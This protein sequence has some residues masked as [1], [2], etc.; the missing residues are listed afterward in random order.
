MIEHCWKYHKE[1]P[2]VECEICKKIV[3]SA[4]YED[5][6]KSHDEPKK[7]VDKRRNF[8]KVFV[9]VKSDNKYYFDVKYQCNLC[10]QKLDYSELDKHRELH[11]KNQ[12]GLKI[13]SLVKKIQMGKKRN[14]EDEN[15]DEKNVEK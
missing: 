3:S 10:F 15:S 7:R 6:H 11:A 5:H 9:K 1:R 8:K 4:N 14:I 2:F 13:A 12:S